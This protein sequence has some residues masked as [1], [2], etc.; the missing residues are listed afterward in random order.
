MRSVS[1]LSRLSGVSVRALHHY[2]AI[3]LL[4]PTLRTEAGYRL[5][6][7]D[8]LKRLQVILIF[9]ELEFP[10]KEI[11]E[12][13]DN[14][15]LDLKEVLKGQISIL[16]MRKKHLDDL[17]SLADTMIRK[18]GDPVGFSVF[19]K[20]RMEAYEAEVRERWGGSEAYA[21]YQKKKSFTEGS[22]KEMMKLFTA[23]GAL[24]DLPPEV[25]EVQKQVSALQTFIS[26]HYYPCDKKILASLGLMYTEDERFRENIDSA[27]G[28]G[29]A[30]FVRKAIEIFCK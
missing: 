10:L 4:P 26:E 14:P 16:N 22:E 28:K 18:G 12:I 17:I 23:F 27:G 3:G 8:A 1:E 13:L 6:D 20:S 9:R 5:Y 21:A 24:K 7:D 15:G 29:T 11:R 30:V 2:D 25:P 19:D